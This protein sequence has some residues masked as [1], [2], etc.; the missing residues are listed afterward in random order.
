MLHTPT[1][2][3]MEAGEIAKALGLERAT[4]LRKRNGLIINEG[5]PAPLPGHSLRW[6]RAG[7]DKWLAQYGEL[8]A[9]AMR[10]SGT[11][12]RIHVDREAL[13]AKYAAR[14]AA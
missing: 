7:V 13:T 12:V 2:A 1:P 10:T 8:K 9:H 11:M 6:H 14:N 5:M 4:F 3:F